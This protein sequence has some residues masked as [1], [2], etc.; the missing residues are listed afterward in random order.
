LAHRRNIRGELLVRSNLSVSC[1][2]SA[3]QPGRRYGMHRMGV[4]HIA[5][6]S[7]DDVDLSNVNFAFYN[8]WPSNLTAGNWKVGVV[9]D[10]AASDEQTQALERILSGQEGGTFGELAQL[11]TEFLGTERGT[12]SFSDGETGVGRCGRQ[13]RDQV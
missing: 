7:L 9:V 11:I 8:Y 2:R 5:E 10:D 4:F 6:G 13:D 1:G 3:Q 12:V